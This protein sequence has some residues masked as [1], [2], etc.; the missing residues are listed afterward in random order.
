MRA[1]KTLLVCCMLLLSTGLWAQSVSKVNFDIVKD[2]ITDSTSDYYYPK[3]INR[4]REGDTTFSHQD[5]YHLYYGTV[6][7]EYYYPYGTSNTK[8]EFLE[9]YKEHHYDNAIKLGKQII[10]Y[11]PVDLE[12]LF[13]LSVSCLKTGRDEEKR[14]YAKHYYSFLDV[15]YYSG[16]GESLESALV[17]TSVDHEYYIAGDLGLRVK[18]HDLIDDCDVL[19]FSKKDQKKLKGTKKI[20][21]LYFNVRMPLLSLSKSYKDVDLPEPDEE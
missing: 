2:N 14:F 11:Y 6:F 1:N 17:V 10:K 5:Y 9:E 12:V 4:L 18:G 13:K 16:D 15:I 3:L 21:R 8:K 7:Q 19:Y 20:K